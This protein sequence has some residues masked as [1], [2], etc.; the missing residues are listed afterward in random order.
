MENVPNLSYSFDY[1]LCEGRHFTA[2]S[3]VYPKVL[4]QQAPG[5]YWLKELV[6]NALKCQDLCLSAV[7]FPQYGRWQRESSHPGGHIT[8]GQA[9]QPWRVSCCMVGSL[10]RKLKHPNSQI[11]SMIVW[12]SWDWNNSWQCLMLKAKTISDNLG[13]LGCVWSGTQHTHRTRNE[14]FGAQWHSFYTVSSH[15]LIRSTLLGEFRIPKLESHLLVQH[16]WNTVSRWPC[17]SPECKSQQKQKLSS[18]KACS[19]VHIQS[20]GN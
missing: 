9:P 3:T 4:E 8:R 16:L 2:L 12:L 11:N 15:A 19:P 7:T 1:K 17:T 13:L 5:K 10:W 14:G 20:T 18:H 6:N